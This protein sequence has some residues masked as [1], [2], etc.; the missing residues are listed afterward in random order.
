MKQVLDN[1][2]LKSSV[3]D[4]LCNTFL[5]HRF[6]NLKV[7]ILCIHKQVNIRQQTMTKYSTPFVNVYT[8]VFRV[9][10]HV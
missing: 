6:V 10:K 8:Y 9:F 1:C 5:N 7:K 2:F 3:L 4:F